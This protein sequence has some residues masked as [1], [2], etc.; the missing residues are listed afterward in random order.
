MAFSESIG[1]LLIIVQSAG[2]PPWLQQAIANMNTQF[3]H[4]DNEL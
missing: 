3:D 2:G 1:V 4:I